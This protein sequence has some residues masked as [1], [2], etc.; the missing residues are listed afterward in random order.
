MAYEYENNEHD[1][2]GENSDC[3]RLDFAAIVL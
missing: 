2:W 1:I 3:G